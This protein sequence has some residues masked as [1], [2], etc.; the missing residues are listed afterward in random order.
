MKNRLLLAFFPI[1]LCGIS[2]SIG[3]LYTYITNRGELVWS[4]DTAVAAI[5]AAVIGGLVTVIGF[6]L[7]ERRRTREIIKKLEG[8]SSE[9]KIVPPVK[10]D[11]LEIRR[12]VTATIIPSLKTTENISDG[13]KAVV[14]ELNFRKGVRSESSIKTLD[15]LKAGMD[16]VFEENVRLNK[17]I[18]EQAEEIGSLKTK[19]QELEAKNQALEKQLAGYKKQKEIQAVPDRDER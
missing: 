8:I 5:I 6:L 4:M 2:V 19:N 16:T 10:E 7:P 15:A 11:T 17:T 9:T 14:D 18:K 12:N 3:C 13:V 1:I